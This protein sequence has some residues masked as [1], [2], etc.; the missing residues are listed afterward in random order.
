MG[1]SDYIAI[2]SVVIALVA[3]ITTIFQLRAAK[4]HNILSVRPL[5]HMHI[6][7]D[8]ALK[9]SFE[10]KGLGPAVIMQ[11]TFIIDGKQFNNPSYK[12]LHNALSMISVDDFKLLE[13][14][15]HLP[16]TGTAYKVGEQIDL[17][18]FSVID[19]SPSPD[20]YELLKKKVEVFL[21]YQSLY[22]EKAFA[23]GSREYS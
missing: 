1:S 12:Q 16:V 19:G 17:L 8:D 9:Y 23:C 6:E 7:N 13:Y 2:A 4:I 10:N 22:Q 11:T 14:E 18:K 5:L 20:F 15:F 21:V 3:L